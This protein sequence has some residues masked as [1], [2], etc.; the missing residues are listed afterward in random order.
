VDVRLLGPLQVFDDAGEA[1]TVSGAKP[2]ALLAE[3]ALRPGRVVSADRLVEDL[4][5]DEA[6]ATAANSLQQLVSKLRR[7]L[8]EGMVVTR[9]P[10]YVLD[11]A[12]DC[13]DIVRFSRLSAKGREALA[14]GEAEP[15]ARTLE[16]ALALWRGDALAEFAY[17]E[18]ARAE[19]TRLEEERMGVAEDRVEANLAC[20]RHGQLVAEL[21]ALVAEEPLRERRRG[22][23]MLALY[24]SGRQ[25]DALR[26]YQDA[27]RTLG[28]E[29]GLEPGPELRRLEAAMLANDPALDLPDRVAPRARQPRRRSRLPVPLTPTIGRDKELRDLRAKVEVNRL[30]S[31]VGPG[32]VGK[33]RLAIET[34]RS[35]HETCES[36]AWFIELAPVSD[37][38]TL[39]GSITASLEVP[40][41]PGIGGPGGS[42]PDRLI[43]FLSEKE[44][45]LVLD[46]C[47]HVIEEAARVVESVL[48]ACPELRVLVTS[49]ETLGVPGEQLWPAPPLARDAAVALFADRASAADPGFELGDDAKGVVAEIC[50][51]VDGLPLAIELAAARVRAFP[52]AQIA[53][54]LDD[55][56]RLLNDG[57]RTAAARQ[58]S[59][60]AVVDWSYDLLFDDERRLFERLSV[61]SGGCQI[62]AVC[63]VCADEHLSAADIPDLLMRLVDKSVLVAQ[64][65]GPEARFSMLQTLADYARDRLAATGDEKTVQDRHRRWFAQLAG[66]GLEAFKG[67]DQLG[68]IL[69]VESEMDN[70]RSAL[71]YA[72][73]SK[74]AE[75]AMLIAGGLGW[76][77]QE[78]GRASEGLRWM[79]V[80]AACDGDATPGAR[81][82]ALAWRKILSRHAGL[83]DPGPTADELITVALQA[84]DE[85]LLAWTHGILAELALSRGDLPAALDWYRSSRRLVAGQSDAFT[86]VWVAFI[87]ATVALLAGDNAAAEQHWAQCVAASRKTGSIAFEA[88]A[89]VQLS[90]FAESR[91]DYE[92]A[93]ELLR[94]SMRMTSQLGFHAR[95]VTYYVRLAN[96][97]GL[98]GDQE[99][100]SALFA[101][102]ERVAAH[103]ALGLALARALTGLAVRHRHAGRLDLAED[104]SCR[105]LD[106]Y[107]AEGH[108]G[109]VAASLRTLGFI[110]EVRGEIAQAESRH[111]EALTVAQRLGDPKSL[112]L[113]MEG[114]AGIA[115]HEQNPRQCAS[116]LG[117]AA[118]LRG[119]HGVPPSALVALSGTQRT[120]SSGMLDDRFD[121]ERIEADARKVL[122][123]PQFEATFAAGAAADLDELINS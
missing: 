71:A 118:R 35:F 27:R 113:C 108:D 34:A 106:I 117:A 51:R 22:Q 16:E 9:P 39:V 122:G 19:A 24:R 42:E 29:L 97:A 90:N 43:D 87:D 36:G 11:V 120:I 45:L 85:E 99:G 83:P 8:P 31:V 79:N 88:A 102:A 38:N 28:D 76:Y 4:W 55:R 26:Q 3:L 66:G 13:V 25:A 21:E 93:T 98:Q 47:E 89:G 5:G 63:S 104:A 61:F 49:R 77:W 59:L 14:A 70:L 119:G 48:S 84:H 115:L 78:N 91:G 10:G 100:A 53:A 81:M 60:R 107:Q 17:D 80:A 50:D 18:F 123:D 116:L 20:G 58:H 37:A 73:D 65:R 69:S 6:P 41:L 1:V 54:R 32:G 44:G 40:D 109:G 68:W 82:W 74:D 72:S 121:A 46:N 86:A 57:A 56:F 67:R 33:T 96:L 95:D 12:P 105:A 52:V 112:A 62:D 103:E 110:S 114:L 2:R 75:S 94:G 101:E 111:R 15:A 30:V 23:L 64:H 92:R 7:V